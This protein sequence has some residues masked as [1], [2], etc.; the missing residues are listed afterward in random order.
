MSVFVTNTGL[1][2]IS[3]Q[4]KVISTQ[5][6]TWIQN[7]KKNTCLTTRPKKKHSFMLKWE[8]KLDLQHEIRLFEREREREKKTISNNHFL[9]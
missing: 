4:E 8:W 3:G 2:I 9:F 7:V 1:A 5:K 6:M